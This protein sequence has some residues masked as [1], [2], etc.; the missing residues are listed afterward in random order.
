MAKAWARGLYNSKRWRSAR[1]EVLRRD[2]YTCQHCHGRAE[3]VHHLVE[4]TP[5]NIQDDAIAFGLD[6]LQALCWRCH[7]DVTHK[8]GDLVDGFEFDEQGQVVPRR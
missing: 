3:E 5:T 6:N 1:A 2:R 4:L 8:R 7:R